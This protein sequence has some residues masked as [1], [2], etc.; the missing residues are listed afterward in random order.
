VSRRASYAV[1]IFLLGAAGSV[2]GAEYSVTFLGN[3]LKSGLEDWVQ[4]PPN[5]LVDASLK[6]GYVVGVHDALSGASVCTP[7]QVT[8]DQV[9]DVTLKFL[10]NQPE[11]LHRGA[12]QIVE[13]SLKAVWP[14]GST[15]AKYWRGNDLK[16]NLEA[17]ESRAVEV[18]TTV[19][20]ASMAAGYVLG[21]MDTR[22]DDQ[23]ICTPSGVT[24]GQSASIALTFMRENPEILDMFADEIVSRHF[25]TIWPCKARNSKR[26]QSS[27]AATTSQSPPPPPLTRAVQKQTPKPKPTPKADSP[28]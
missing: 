23:K 15:Y 2:T 5:N 21:V 6:A 3:E 26:T 18:D 24:V 17:W 10:R 1:V 16:A 13:Q 12:D 11:I 20:N 27:D 25:A 28:F 9:I 8:V 19:A 14:C 22:S 7:T 4:H